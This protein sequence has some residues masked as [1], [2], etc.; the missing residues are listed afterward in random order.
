MSFDSASD[1]TRAAVAREAGRAV[2]AG[3]AFAD[4]TPQMIEFYRR[5]IATDPRLSEYPPGYP[6]PQEPA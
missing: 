4:L 2:P 1:E 3:I 5:L 6:R